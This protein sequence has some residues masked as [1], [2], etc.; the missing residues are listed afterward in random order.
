MGTLVVNKVRQGDREKKQ[1]WNTL[2]YFMQNTLF[3]LCRI[4]Y[5]FISVNSQN[6]YNSLYTY[7]TTGSVKQIYQPTNLPTNKPSKEPN[8][9]PTEPPSNRPTNQPTHPP[10][11]PH[12]EDCPSD[13]LSHFNMVQLLYYQEYLH[14]HK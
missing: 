10:K 11:T 8:E 5:Y 3:I 7:K 4:L 9:P 6:M 13:N 14:T 1:V 2:F 12:I